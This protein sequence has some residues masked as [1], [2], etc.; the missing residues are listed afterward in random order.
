M[1]AGVAWAQH[2]GIAKVEVRVDDGEWQDA[3]LAAVTG[4]DTWRQWRFVWDAEPGRA[5]S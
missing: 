5:S 4:P 3:E 1:V 2:T